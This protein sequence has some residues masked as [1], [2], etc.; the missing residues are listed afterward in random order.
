M[1]DFVKIQGSACI[2]V[3]DKD[4]NITYQAEKKNT[5]TNV[6]FAAL[7]GLAGNV[8][9][10]SPFIYLALGTSTTGPA[11]S[12][13]TLVAEIIDSG[14]AR[15]AATISRS[16]FTQTN[17]TLQLDYTWTASGAKTIN[18][19]GVFNAISSGV[20]LGRL[21]TGTMSVSSGNTV[22]ITYKVKFS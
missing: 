17:D 14:L 22:I 2:T 19:V 8:G 9:S 20:M 13:T 4:G 12:Q 10:V 15:A 1:K 16:T 6:G 7:A 21:L 18:E 3:K 11:P 5:I